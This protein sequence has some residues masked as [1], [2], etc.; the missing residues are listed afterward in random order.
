MTTDQGEYLSLPYWLTGVVL[1]LA[2][3]FAI[4]CDFAVGAIA[5]A[6]QMVVSQ[7]VF[8]TSPVYQ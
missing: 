4:R 1:Y 5:G 2:L 8:L 7:E 3:I 6:S